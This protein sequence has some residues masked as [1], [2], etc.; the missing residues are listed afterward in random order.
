MNTPIVV[1]EDSFQVA[2]AKAVLALGYNNWNA[3]NFVVQINNPL[4]FDEEIHLIMENFASNHNGIKSQ[5]VVQHTIFPQQ[6]YKEGVTRDKL[7]RAYW[8]YFNIYNKKHWGTY[9]ERMIRYQTSKGDIDQ[10]GK[11]IDHINDR[12]TN[13]GAAHTILIP[14]PHKDSNKIMGAPCLNY[15]TVQVEKQQQV[16]MINLLAVYRNHDFRARAY[17]NYWGL[18]SLLNYICNETN[19]KIGMITC[20]SSRASIPNSKVELSG[21]ANKIIGHFYL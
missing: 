21:L 17:G 15:L 4:L 7:Y 9:F 19:S 13:Y 8:K 1:C 3:W 2:W 5:K 12:T 16:R 20:I 18:C 6:F 14:Y 10:L 11:I